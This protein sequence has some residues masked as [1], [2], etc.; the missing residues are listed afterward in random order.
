MPVLTLQV[1]V[2]TMAGIMIYDGLWGPQVAAMNLAG[3]T[4][5]DP[6]AG[7]RHIRSARSRQY[8]VHGVPS[9]LAQYTDSSMVACRP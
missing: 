4:A 7:D 1:L 6:L 8:L 9:Y 5:M 3:D 2:G